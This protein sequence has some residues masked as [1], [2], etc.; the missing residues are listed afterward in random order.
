MRNE[1]GEIGERANSREQ[2]KMRNE[3]GEMRNA[4]K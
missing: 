2:R 1:K 4:K 3:K